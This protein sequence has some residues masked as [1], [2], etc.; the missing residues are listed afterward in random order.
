MVN[1]NCIRCLVIQILL[2]YIEFVRAFFWFSLFFLACSRYVLVSRMA[3][4]SGVRS[5]DGYYRTYNVDKWARIMN[6]F[7]WWY[8]CNLFFRASSGWRYFHFGEGNDIS[9]YIKSSQSICLVENEWETIVKIDEWE[10][11]VMYWFP[12]FTCLFLTKN[13]YFYYWFKIVRFIVL[14]LW[15]MH[16][17]F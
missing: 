14:K 6:G 1:R 3:R 5:F 17:A 15:L 13:G 16:L 4:Q 8:M 12:L 11:L 7:V 10:L 2:W 9:L